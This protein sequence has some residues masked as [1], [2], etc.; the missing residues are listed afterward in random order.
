MALWYSN[1]GK[2]KSLLVAIIKCDCNLECIDVR[3]FQAVIKAYIILKWI[4]HYRSFSEMFLL[5][6]TSQKLTS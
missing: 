3:K 1:K 4:F 6:T 5:C 2:K